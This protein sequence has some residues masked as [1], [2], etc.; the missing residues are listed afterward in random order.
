VKLRKDSALHGT[1]RVR[2]GSLINSGFVSYVETKLASKAG[3]QLAGN[4]STRNNG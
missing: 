4:R 2:V 1:A 3:Q